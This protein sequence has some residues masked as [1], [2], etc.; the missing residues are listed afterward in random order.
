ME[1]REFLFDIT[2]KQDVF[3]S[4]QI[5]SSV[6]IVCSEAFLSTLMAAMCPLHFARMT[7]TLLTVD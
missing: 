5:T 1:I 6:V 3:K 7:S 2:N 4:F